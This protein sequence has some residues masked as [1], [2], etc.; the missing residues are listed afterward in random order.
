VIPDRYPGEGP[1]GGVLTALS[2][3]AADW[4]LVLAC[5]M[6]GIS[7]DFLDSLLHSAGEL[8]N[9]VLAPSGPSGRPEPLCAVYHRRALAPFA[10]VFARG[11]RRMSAALAAVATAVLPVAGMDPFQN[12][13]T[14]EDWAAYAR[15]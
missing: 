11:E 13:N 9:D 12:V 4:N 14:P 8:G 3:T 5:D 6:P 1:L 10:A 15:D 2:H 7:A